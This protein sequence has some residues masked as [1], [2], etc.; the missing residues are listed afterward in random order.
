MARSMTTN[1]LLPVMLIV[2]GFAAVMYLSAFIEQVRPGLPEEYADSDLTMN[3]SSL[4]GFAFGT[5]GLMA[6][7]YYMRAIQYVGEKI[8]NSKSEFIN[9]DDLRDLNPRLLYPL[10]DNATDLD[11]HYLEAYLYGAIIMPAIDPDKAVAIAEK[12][13]ANNPNQWRLYGPLGYIYWRLGRYE[14]A[15]EI[16][17]RG[18]EIEGAPSFM[19]M[20]AA[21]MKTRGGSR[22]TARAIYQNMLESS[23]DDQVKITAHRRLQQL[24]S[25]DDRD[26]IDAAL[27]QYQ[28]AN[29]RCA[30]SLAEIVTKLM[31]VKLPENRDFIVDK[32]HNLVDPTGAPYL[33]DKE[34]CRSQLDLSRS[35]IASQ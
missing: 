32:S 7:W 31:T 10:L 29:G 4:K 20:M 25:L 11:P 28:E 30:N 19:K 5:E 14:K 15:S 9:L 13:V 27:A 16:Y 26:A 17:E 18:S 24:D 33:L 35:T 34:N 8:I 1:F 2:A 22:E 6:D 3:G 12:G 23:D 21:S